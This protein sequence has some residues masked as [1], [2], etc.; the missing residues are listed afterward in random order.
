MLMCRQLVAA[1]TPDRRAARA[2]APSRPKSAIP[3]SGPVG[4][5]TVAVE[6][7]RPACGLGACRP[8][9]L[10]HAP[11]EPPGTSRL[12]GQGV[13]KGPRGGIFQSVTATGIDYIRPNGNAHP[14]NLFWKCTGQQGLG[15]TGVP[16]ARTI[17]FASGD[18]VEIA[19]PGVPRAVAS[20]AGGVGWPWSRGAR[21]HCGAAQVRPDPSASA[22]AV[23]WEP[24][25]AGAGW[26]KRCLQ[27]VNT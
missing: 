4:A 25:Y 27:A 14:A 11:A 9:G 10:G 22:C 15:G 16:G 24:R 6:A 18:F 13:F 26:P 3:G 17:N 5:A 12:A 2:R 21:A 23:S 8:A 1:R 19:P 20:K 7:R